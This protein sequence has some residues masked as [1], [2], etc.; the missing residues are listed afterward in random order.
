MPED[1][2]K[3]LGNLTDTLRKVP[4]V[5]TRM[6][7]VGEVFAGRYDIKR[8]L[9]RGGMGMVYLANQSPLGRQVA[10][11][12][13]KPPES[14]DDDPN[15]DERF[16]RE[17]AAAARLQ[18]PN[19]ITVHDF[20]QA[21]D[22]ALY[23]VMEY[24]EGNDLRTVLSHER[25]FTPARAIHV[26]KQVCKSL[27][28]AHRKGIIHRDLKPANVLLCRRDE[29]DDFVKVLDFGLVKFRGEASEITLA[30]KFLGS[31]RY[32]SPEALDRTKEVDHR[33]DIYALGILLYTMITGQPPFDG[34]PMQVL[35]AHL[36]EKPKAMWK[37][38]P[39]AQ[40]TPAL[41]GLVARCLEKDPADR[42]QSM[43]E[44]IIALRTCG[45]AFGHEDTETLDLEVNESLE[46]D[47]EPSSGPTRRADSR[48]P[49][50]PTAIRARREPAPAPK[51]AQAGPRA[52]AP[53]PPRRKIR[54]RR[55]IAPVAVL[56]VV[57]LLLVMVIVVLQLRRDPAPAP[58]ETPGEL[59]GSLAAPGPDEIEVA[60][61]P[62]VALRIETDPPGAEIHIGFDG[63]WSLLGPSPL[64]IAEYRAPTGYS[65]LGLQA[66]LPG[67]EPAE[68][69]VTPVEGAVTWTPRLQRVVV[70]TPKPTPRPTSK[71]TPKPAA[72]A[73]PAPSPQP[74]PAAEAT[75]A[76]KPKPS[77][78]PVPSGYKDNPY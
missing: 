18:H 67:Y 4:A 8:L 9:G 23:I 46:L 32:T 10:I 50:A 56:S 78:D 24:L 77:A 59:A 27:R 68:S 76:P 17:A 49:S 47:P 55:S 69:V 53:E 29:D 28:E 66:S 35:H 63:D 75:P 74:T 73:T 37:I 45:S 43:G 54:R 5:P 42:F 70:D 3:G 44:L 31:P 65:V 72:A 20:G 21:D 26:A 2:T 25:C 58:A 16:L 39:A 51:A 14:L 19:T 33:A 71:P 15:F 62:T 1:G 52:T 48:P 38:N 7:D 34:D 12:I 64:T 57:A 13:L 36:H 6:P 22:G 60:G 41:E 30:G 11:K 61:A 40:T